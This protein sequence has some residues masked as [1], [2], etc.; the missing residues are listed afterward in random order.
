LKNNVENRGITVNM[1]KTKVMISGER[2]KALQKAARWPCGVCG[3]GVGSNSI[4]C[5][6]CHKWVHKKCSGI[7][8][9]MYQP[10]KTW[11]EVVQKDC[12]ARN[13]NKEDAMDRGR[14]KKLIK[15]G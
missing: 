12:Q 9:S 15:I 1:N 14:W 7:N 8:G 2:Q 3:R 10:K 13:L 5:T 11:R 6:S 4:Q